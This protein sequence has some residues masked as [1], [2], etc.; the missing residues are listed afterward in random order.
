MTQFKG[1]RKPKETEFQP[2]TVDNETY[3]IKCCKRKP[4]SLENNRP[5]FVHKSL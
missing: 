3:C 4:S 5:Y 2:E 1:Q